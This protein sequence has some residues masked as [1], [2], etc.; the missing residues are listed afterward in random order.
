MVGWQK[1]CN[2]SKGG[3]RQYHHQLCKIQGKNVR[4]IVAGRVDADIFRTL[5]ADPV[6]DLPQELSDMFL[7]LPDFRN[8][9]SSTAIRLREADTTRE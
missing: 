3:C 5:E 2:G 9:I 6:M 7:S 4:F 8:D 1:L